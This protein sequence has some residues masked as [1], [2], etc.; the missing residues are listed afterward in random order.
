MATDDGEQRVTALDPMVEEALRLGPFHQALQVA[1]AT[2][3]LTLARIEY[4]LA[5]RGFPIGRSTLSYWQQ[6]LRRPERPESMNALRALEDLLGIDQGGLSALLAP[7][8]PRGRWIGYR[9]SGLAWSEMWGSG[10]EIRQLLALDLRRNNDKLL[11]ISLSESLVIGADR[12]M[13]SVEINQVSQARENGADRRMILT[14]VDADHD[15][16][17]VRL[18]DLANCRVGRQRAVGGGTNVAAFELLFDRAL[19][20]AGTHMF[21]YRIDFASGF[22]S[23]RE[24]AERNVE[25]VPSTEGGRA[26]RRQ[27][28]T[29]LLSAQF[30][31]GMLPVRCYHVRMNHVGGHEQVI[32]EL[33][34]NAFGAAHIVLQNVQPGIH[35]I[36]WDWE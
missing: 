35:T 22:L 16:T 26:F 19:P 5:Q 23:A 10:D 20:E 25:L 1:I 30:D 33:T 29:Y 12:R 32:G 8:K 34:V 24:M 3:G 36:R 21:R 14:G 9:G 31:P 27:T 2:S 4:H 11:D 28:H 15:I 17:R 13:Q 18:S 7:R 6:G